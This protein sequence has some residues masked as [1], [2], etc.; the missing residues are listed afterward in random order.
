MKMRAPGSQP[1]A[2]TARMLSLPI[3][4]LG[5]CK[6]APLLRCWWGQVAL[7]AERRFGVWLWTQR[8]DWTELG[9]WPAGYD[10][11]G[12]GLPAAE[13][14]GMLLK[15]ELLGLGGGDLPCPGQG[16]MQGKPCCCPWGA[17]RSQVLAAGLH[18]AA[19]TAK[20]RG[21]LGSGCF[22]GKALLP[23]GRYLFSLQFWAVVSG[24]QQ[25]PLH[26]QL[27]RS[28]GN[29]RLAGHTAG[30][31]GRER[32]GGRLHRQSHA[33]PL[34]PPEWGL[35]LALQKRFPALLFL[36]S[37]RAARQP[38]LLPCAVVTVKP[39]H[40]QP[41]CKPA[42]TLGRGV[43]AWHGAARHLWGSLPVGHPFIV[44]TA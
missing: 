20:H 28:L 21:R 8:M 23:H 17:A 14:A 7:L 35:D 44:P 36:V 31:G 38:C 6:F 10:G 13:L 41:S 24:Q 29:H 30:A 2:Q 32:A 25:R 3:P 43:P 37:S 33:A 16:Q 4:K 5:A 39:Q 40:G 18:S 22:P 27:L 12:A 11:D 1:T 26:V 34:T 15:R 19:A 42:G 9:A